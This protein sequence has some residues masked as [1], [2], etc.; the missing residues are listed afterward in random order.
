ME[1]LGQVQGKGS[2]HLPAPP[3][4]QLAGTVMDAKHPR[5]AEPSWGR[6]LHN[7]N[8]DW[9]LGHLSRF[10]TE[11]KEAQRRGGTC[12]QVTYMPSPGGGQVSDSS[13]QIPSP[14]LFQ[15]SPLPLC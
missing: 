10:T 6:N 12:S 8:P 1:P 13:I 15:P 3:S 4:L 9:L 5:G 14:R 7:F 11:K 2:H